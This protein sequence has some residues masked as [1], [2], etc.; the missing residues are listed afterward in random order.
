LG[1]LT[2]I[3]CLLNKRWVVLI[4]KVLAPEENE[5][6]FRNE[7]FPNIQIINDELERI[8]ADSQGVIR[9]MCVHLLTAGG[10]RIRPLLVLHSGLIFSSLK[11]DLLYAA[12]AV[13]LVHMA[14]LVHDDIIDE[15]NLRRNSPSVNKVWGNH[16]AVLGGDYLFAKAFS[17]LAENNLIRNLNLTVQAIQEMCHGEIIQAAEKFNPDLNLE[18]YY[19][20][21][22]KKTAIL[23]QCACKSGAIVGGADETQIALLGEYGLHMGYAFQIGDDI[24]DFYGD[25][26]I[27]GKPKQ[28][29]LIQGNL[30]LPVILLLNHPQYREWIRGIV[31]NK[32][33]DDE[34]L[35]RVAQ[36]LKESGIIRK[37]FEIAVSH[38]DKAKRNLDSLPKSQSRKYLEDL[39][40][41]LTARTY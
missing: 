40:D 33:F 32:Q 15:S 10:K 26:V 16:A 41:Q 34:N 22:A 7:E 37:S 12:V 24:L 35:K 1:K 28:E 29:D 13:E 14:S 23:L 20:R 25:A 19:K 36:I 18:S 38:I 11:P 2:E 21:I 39:A 6:Q 4:L 30:T 17:V 9:E 5:V 31:I 27:M 3:Q 8:L